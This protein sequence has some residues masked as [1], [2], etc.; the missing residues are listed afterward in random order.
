MLVLILLTLIA[1]FLVEATPGE[2]GLY[3]WVIDSGTAD[4]ASGFEYALTLNSR[5]ACPSSSDHINNLGAISVGVC[6]PD[7]LQESYL[8]NI[9]FMGN[10]SI[11]GDCDASG[12]IMVFEES[13]CNGSALLYQG[14]VFCFQNFMKKGLPSMDW[15]LCCGMGCVMNIINP[16]K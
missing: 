10:I 16:A 5:G 13:G 14:S 7:T 3:E 2:S 12:M 1:T 6:I 9:A 11:I 15:L 8:Q 4:I